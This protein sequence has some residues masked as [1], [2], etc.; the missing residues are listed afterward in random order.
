MIGGKKEMKVNVFSCM[1]KE[2]KQILN[3]QVCFFFLNRRVQQRKAVL[4]ERVLK[5]TT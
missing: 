1:L 4:K 5:S 2:N 3:C